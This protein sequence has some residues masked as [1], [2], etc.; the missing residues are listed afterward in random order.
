MVLT[1]GILAALVEL[2]DSGVGQVVDTSILAGATSLTTSTYEAIANGMRTE[3]RWTFTGDGAAPFYNTYETSDGCYIAVSAIE[4]EFY[5]ELVDVLGFTLAELPDQYDRTTWPATKGLFAAR[6]RTKTRDEWC[7]LAEH[8]DACLGPVLTLAEAPH[9]PHHM[10]ERTF[11][12]VDGV[13]QP[14]PVPQFSR[15]P[16]GI[17]TRRASLGEHTV[18]ALQEWGFRE[19]EVLRLLKSAVLVATDTVGEAG[20]LSDLC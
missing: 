3:A 13:V 14:G 11:I 9:H 4:P 16:P 19:D 1:I 18:S 20:Q 17:P 8:R 12:N 7:E 6:V 2:R 10:A 5:K 15:T